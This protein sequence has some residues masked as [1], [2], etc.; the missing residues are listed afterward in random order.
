[1]LKLLLTAK[2]D[3]NVCDFSNIL[4][5]NFNGD[6]KMYADEK[7]QKTKGTAHSKRVFYFNFI[8]VAMT[9]QSTFDV[10]TTFFIVILIGSQHL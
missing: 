7:K 2:R 5:P 6:G 4:L 10:I 1:M 3:K 8:N 9:G